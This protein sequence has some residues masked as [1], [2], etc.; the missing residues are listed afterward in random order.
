MLHIPSPGWLRQLDVTLGRV[1][2]A[3]VLYSCSGGCFPTFDYPSSVT[4]VSLL[5]LDMS[6]DDVTPGPDMEIVPRPWV[7]NVEEWS[8][9]VKRRLMIQRL[10]LKQRGK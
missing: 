4:L 5:G 7:I 10:R 3:R 6:L 2:V 1:V 9:R 8:C